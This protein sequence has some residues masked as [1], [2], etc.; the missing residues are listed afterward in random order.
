MNIAPT[1]AEIVRV[2]MIEDKRWKSGD[3]CLWRGHFGIV[4]IVNQEMGWVTF[5]NNERGV[6]TLAQLSRPTRLPGDLEGMKVTGKR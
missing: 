1:G 2:L 6:I 4:T 3:S 5:D